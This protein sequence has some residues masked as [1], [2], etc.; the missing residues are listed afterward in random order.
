LRRSSQAQSS[1]YAMLFL[2]GAV[3]FV[4]AVMVVLVIALTA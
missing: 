4:V 1:Y 2:F 3:M